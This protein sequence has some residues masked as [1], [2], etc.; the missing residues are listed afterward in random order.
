MISGPSGVGASAHE[1]GALPCDYMALPIRRELASTGWALLLSIGLVHCSDPSG[2]EAT[3]VT[4]Q[5]CGRE[6][7][8]AEACTG[9]EALFL[10][11]VQSGET[12]TGHY[13]EAYGKD[14][15]E[16]QSGKFVGGRL[17]FFYTFG[18][19][20]VDAELHAAQNT[21]TGTF[22]TTKAS[23]PIPVTLHRVP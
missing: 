19:D 13:C 15:Y 1:H 16:L 8:T 17:T 22:T 23:A 2:G 3:V 11:L 21:L 9:D 12:V 14:C 10:D 20:R 4:G 18:V 6:V 7:A 5:W